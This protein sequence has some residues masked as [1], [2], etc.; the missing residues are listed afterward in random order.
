MLYSLIPNYQYTY[1][2]TFSI[3]VVQARNIDVN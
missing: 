3:I 2:F 1:K